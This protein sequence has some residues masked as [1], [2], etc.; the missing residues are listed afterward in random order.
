MLRKLLAPFAPASPAAEDAADL[1]TI[2]FRDADGRERTLAEFAGRVVLIVNVASKCG[3]TRQ[4][5][6]LEALYRKHKDEGL[7]I[8]AF[9][10]NDFGGQ[11]PGSLDEIREFCRVNHGVTFPVMDKITIRGRAKHPL[12]AAMPGRVMWN[13]AKHLVGRD[14]RHLAF[15]GSRTRPDAPALAHAITTALR[16]GLLPEPPAPVK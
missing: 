13:F 14:G 4:Y 5:D 9:P 3:F 15:F 7:V 2:P 6:G 11:E 8:L 16:T 10:C 1:R 12:Y